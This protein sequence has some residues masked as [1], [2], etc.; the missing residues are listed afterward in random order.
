MTGTRMKT[1]MEF[2]VL[3]SSCAVLISHHTLYTQKPTSHLSLVTRL[4]QA[5]YNSRRIIP[6]VRKFAAYG[7]CSAYSS[8]RVVPAV[9]KVPVA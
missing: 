7:S 9:R 4:P 2:K 5:A 1:V 6:A 3:G 8:R